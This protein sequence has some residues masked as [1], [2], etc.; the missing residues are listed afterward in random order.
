MHN[1][2]LYLCQA[3]ELHPKDAIVHNN[4]ANAYKKIAALD[5]AISHYTQALHIDPQY[6]HAHNNLAS[7]Y[8][9][10]GQF[11][12]A[13]SH[14]RAAVHAQP[15]FAAAH[16]NLGLLLLKNNQLKAAEKQF[17]NVL[18]LNPNHADAQ[19]YLGALQLEANQLE[20]AEKSFH[21]AL[22]I[23]SEHV[24]ALANLGVVALKH[25]K[26]QLAVDYFTKA[27]A[28]D[29]DNLDARNNIA[30]T[31]I[32]NDLFENAL[33]HYDVLLEHEP[34]NIEY[35]YNAGVAQMALGHLKEATTLFETILTLEDD[36]FATLNNLAAIHIRLG[37][38]DQAIVLLEHALVANPHDKTSQFML[39]ALTGDK[40]NAQACPSYVNNLFNNYALFYEQHLQGSLNYSLPHLIARV[41]H[42]LNCLKVNYTIDLGCGTGLCG[43]VLRE[44]TKH[45]IGVD[46]AAKMLAIAKKKGIYDQLV[47]E[48]LI[49]FLQKNKQCYELA[50]AA[51]VFPYLGELNALFA[52]LQ[53]RVASDGI[54]IF[55]HE[56]CDQEPWQLQETARFCHHPDYIKTLC[57]K[58]GFEI[59]Y[60]EKVVAR[61]QNEQPLYV[62]LYA[63]KYS[64]K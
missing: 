9:S 32:H 49:T 31:F 33:M 42:Q 8:A 26:S 58:H 59:V 40:K 16:Y 53:Q 35:L 52:I 51:D 10:Q 57:A 12:Q 13:L 38:H 48:E 61:L 60:Q 20:K 37:H 63:T 23:N 46:I 17:K 1:A 44:L 11:Q 50:V 2:I 25:Q 7:I 54:F 27:L 47:E 5:K 14:Y 6:A 29:N 62:M 3:I 41:L 15:D 24:E 64:T 18:T 45:L 22:M 34:H 21:K 30:A 19:F 28:L 4:L 36:H 39:H 43:V 55:S 56:I